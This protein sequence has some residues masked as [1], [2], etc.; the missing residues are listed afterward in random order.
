[1]P[2]GKNPKFEKNGFLAIFPD[3]ALFQSKIKLSGHNVEVS[4]NHLSQLLAGAVKE[5]SP[6]PSKELMSVSIFLY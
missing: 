5:G 1:M 6:D 3:F 2:K 4:P